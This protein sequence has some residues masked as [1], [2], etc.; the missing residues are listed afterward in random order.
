MNIQSMRVRSHRSIATNEHVPE[1]AAEC[2][3]TLKSYERLRASGCCEEGAHPD[4][5]GA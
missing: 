5:A 2:Y 4:H 3:R 1:Q